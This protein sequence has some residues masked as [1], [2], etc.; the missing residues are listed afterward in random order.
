M[1]DTDKSIKASGVC[2]DVEKYTKRSLKQVA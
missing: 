1:K 2:S